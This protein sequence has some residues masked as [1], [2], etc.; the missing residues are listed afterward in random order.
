M[1]APA[2]ITVA[3]ISAIAVAVVL[4]TQL[5]SPPQKPAPVTDQRV[6][7]A[8]TPAAPAPAQPAPAPPA[9]E[10]HPA[11][12]AKPDVVPTP[13]AEEAVAAESAADDSVDAD[14]GA[15]EAADDNADDEG[16][17]SSSVDA[18]HAADLLAD[19]VA[20]QDAMATNEGETPPPGVQ[21]L[22]TF[23][24][25]SSSDWSEATEQQVEAAL[26]QWLDNL[27]AEVRDHIEIIHVE[28]RETLCQILAADNEAGRQNERAEASQEWQQAI[29]TLPQQPWWNELGFV[30]VS[31]AVN[32]DAESGYVL[33]QTYL[34][35]EVKPA[36]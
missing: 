16:D 8:A 5:P 19:W 9:A 33:Y 32:T 7:A 21:A 36:G 15:E 22:R 34:R 3:A 14:A 18:G 24:H 31:N 23:D 6:A 30:D 28:C 2:L 20:K 17:A 27:P 12:P 11:E 25:E 29:A 10:A 4:L 35:R 13:K 1:R 26:N